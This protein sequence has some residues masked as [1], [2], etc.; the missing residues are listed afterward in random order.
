MKKYNWTKLSDVFFLIF[1]VLFII[2][3]PI[4]HEQKTLVAEMIFFGIYWA[5]ILACVRTIISLL[6]K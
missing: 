5:M 2:Y 1:F 3:I 4:W 6:R